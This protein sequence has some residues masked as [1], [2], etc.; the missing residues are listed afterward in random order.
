VLHGVKRWITHAGVA[1]H[2]LVFAVTDPD[3]RRISAFVVHRDDPGVSFGPPEDK[4]GLRGSPTAEIRLDGV[5]IPADRL[6]GGEAP[7]CRSR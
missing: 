1:D 7:G 3:T 6:V 2:Y 5:R 4:M